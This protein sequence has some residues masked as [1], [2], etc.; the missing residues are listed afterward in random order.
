MTTSKDNYVSDSEHDYSRG[1]Y[2]CVLESD[3]GIIRIV[4]K[5]SLLKG[6]AVNI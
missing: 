1:G 4:Y 5:D 3:Y 6:G 2:Q